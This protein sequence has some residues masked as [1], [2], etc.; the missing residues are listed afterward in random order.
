MRYKKILC[1]RIPRLVG[2]VVSCVFAV[3]D[4]GAGVIVLENLKAR[5]RRTETCTV[6][7]GV[8]RMVVV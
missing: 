8:G 2:C 4:E 3:V 5:Q 1:N 7:K 6:P